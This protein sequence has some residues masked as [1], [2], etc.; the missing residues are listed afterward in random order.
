[1]A[2]DLLTVVDVLTSPDFPIG[3]SNLTFA[4]NGFIIFSHDGINPSTII[5]GFWE[6]TEIGTQWGGTGNIGM[7]PYS[8]ICGGITDYDPL[9]SVAAGTPGYVLTYT[10][11]TS[12][13]TW[14]PSGGGGGEQLQV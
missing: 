1:M 12:L 6:S 4:D 3:Y 5:T 13:P 14:Q 10:S 2:S 7:D 9:Q 8:V 11:S